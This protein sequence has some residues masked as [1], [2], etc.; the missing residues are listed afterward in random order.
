MKKFIVLSL[1]LLSSIGRP[2]SADTCNFSADEPLGGSISD[3]CGDCTPN[4]VCSPRT[5]LRPRSITTDLTYRNAMTFYQRYNGAR[6]AILTYDS[7]FIYQK[8]RNGLTIG[9]GFFGKDPFVVSQ[10]DGD[11]NSVN[12]GLISAQPE[13][14]LSEVRISPKRRVFAWLN[15]FIFNF[16][17][18]IEG[19][20]ADVGF[21]VVKAHH[22]IGFSEKAVTPGDIPGLATVED[23]FT[24]LGVF[25]TV[26]RS[27]AVDDVEI[28]VGYDYSYCGSHY[29]GV[30]V[31][32]SQATGPKYDNTMLFQPL[33]GSRH[34]GIGTG[35]RALYNLPCD[36]TL[37]TEI[38]YQFKFHKEGPRL[39]DLCNG[40][41]SRFLLVAPENN[42]FDAVSGTTLLKHTVLVDVRSTVDWW[43]AL[44]Y[45]YCKWGFEGAYNLFWRQSERIH[46][47]PFTFDGFGVFDKT[48]CGNLTSESNALITEGFGQG[49]P[50]P[51]F[52]RLT[53]RDVN[54]A[55]GATRSA[56]SHTFSGTLTYEDCLQGCYPWMIALGGRYEMADRSRKRRGKTLENWGVF[57][58]TSFSI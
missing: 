6:E 19:L 17:P 50:D 15:Q 18:L 7:S 5:Y 3:D 35:F 49:T 34:S 13:G 20:W 4:V 37:M 22:T 28:R 12:L 31:L 2:L 46:C 36:F 26:A 29:L 58:K 10:Q 39:F 53:T 54:F 43:L 55:S 23:A 42:R 48:R 33:V 9:A 27:T 52:V 16:D 30:Y 8:S 41:L 32:G 57:L 25:P 40:P 47:S 51:T 45:Q 21:A 44:H 38:K 11:I 24:Q 1:L 56:L 14:F